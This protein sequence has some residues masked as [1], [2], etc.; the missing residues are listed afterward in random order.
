[1]INYIPPD[2]AITTSASS[3]AEGL[4]MGPAVVVCWFGTS[5]TN[6][7][8][9]TRTISSTIGLFSVV[10]KDNTVSPICRGG[11]LI[12][13]SLIRGEVAVLVGVW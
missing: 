2:G 11:V 8:C 12:G 13:F 5:G 6:T 3:D 10:I 7:G 9:T 1:M 4:V